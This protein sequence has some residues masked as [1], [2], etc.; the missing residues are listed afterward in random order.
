MI[1]LGKLQLHRQAD[2]KMYRNIPEHSKL[3]FLGWNTGLVSMV[4]FTG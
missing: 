4:S 3:S 2:M 1:W